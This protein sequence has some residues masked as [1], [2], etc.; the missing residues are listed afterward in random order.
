MVK[1][2]SR[3]SKWIIAGFGFLVFGLS[4]TKWLTD[5]PYWQKAEGALIDRRYLLRGEQP[6]DPDIILV[7]VEN[8]SFKLSALAPEEIAASPTLQL[9]QHP[10]PW[11]RRVYAAVLEKLMGAGAKVVVFDFVFAS[12]TEGDNDLAKAL[13]KYKSHVLVGE[14]FAE[15]E[16][17]N[18]ESISS[19]G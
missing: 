11:D 19:N 3:H 8:S 16:G 10:W 7:G 12:E 15:E 9:M 6:P 13:L 18:H 1:F 2:L 5:E 4:Q 14:D 17:P